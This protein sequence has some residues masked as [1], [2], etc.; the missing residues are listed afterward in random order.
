MK[1]LI[2]VSF[3]LFMVVGSA[4]S[5][6]DT[7][8]LQVNRSYHQGISIGVYFSN[9]IKGTDWSFDHY[10][11]LD[12]NFNNKIRAGLYFGYS[13]QIYFTKRFYCKAEIYYNHNKNSVIYHEWIRNGSIGTIND[14]NF[15]ASY[16][17]VSLRLLP[18]MAFGENYIF[19]LFAGPYF[20]APFLVKY[21]GQITSNSW[22]ELTETEISS[23]ILTNNEIHKK[24]EKGF[25]GLVGIRLDVPVNYN[26]L[27]LEFGLGKSFIN[28]IKFPNTKESFKTVSLIYL[29]KT[30]KPG[31]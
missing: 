3:F 19:N 15:T 13:R 10:H 4:N 11:T 31:A 7:T 22:D 24:L 21:S 20:D 6:N 29:F 16:S 28:I 5:Q 25:G 14:A 18:C 26:Y 9:F 2:L 8:K 1:K 12:A 27:G 23:S 30:K 17:R